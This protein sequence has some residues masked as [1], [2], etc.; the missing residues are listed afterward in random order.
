[1][2]RSAVVLLCLPGVFAFTRLAAQ[3]Q[4]SWIRSA[5]PDG[6]FSLQQPAGWVAKFGRSNLRLSNAARD[7]EIV[8]IRLPRDQSKTPN[9]YA[10]SVV[11]SFQKS[12]A[13]FTMTNFQSQ[14]DAA[15]FLVTYKSGGKD[16]SGPGALVVKAGAAWWVNYGSP[17]TANLTRGAELIAGVAKSV[18]DGSASVA[19][20]QPAPQAAPA[21][22][23]SFTLMGNWGTVGYYG[24]LVNSRGMAVQSR[25][26]GEWYKFDPDGTYRY[27]MAASG[28]IVTGVV[29]CVGTYE[30]SGNTVRLHQ[31]TESWS[32]MPSASNQ[33][34]PYKDKPMPRE[35]TL[36]IEPRG[37]GE[38]IV[39]EG[40]SA[41]TYHRQPDSK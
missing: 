24:E 19:P 4:I 39:R 35:V 23:Q 1:M 29:I 16:Y 36:T 12:L 37:P 10:G 30:A 33:K 3:D 28:R 25:Y 2:R 32:P 21:Q 14:G 38:M 7:E 41:T 26:S 22:P 27:S 15:A 6:S 31:K 8:V 40:T 13:A 18:T 9:D 17:S 34:P 5:A 11:R 20:A